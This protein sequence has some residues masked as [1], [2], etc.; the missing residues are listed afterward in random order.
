MKRV[1]LELGGHAPVIVC[2]D[3][4]SALAVKAAGRTT[5]RNA[6]QV[7]I[8]PTRFLVHPSFEKEFASALTSHAKALKAG[9]GLAERTQTGSLANAR[10][11][12][13]MRSIAGGGAQDRRN[14]GT[15]PTALAHSVAVY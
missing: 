2:E 15:L 7:C 6:G 13:A 8:S 9:D 1:K 14:A 5:F 12:A 11:V 3:A 10:R 4:D